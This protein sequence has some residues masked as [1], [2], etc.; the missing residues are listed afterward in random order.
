MQYEDVFEE[1]HEPD[2]RTYLGGAGGPLRHSGIGIAS[3]VLSLLAII[4]FVG[5]FVY[6]IMIGISD[7]AG[8]SGS[9]AALESTTFE[10]AAGLSVFGSIGLDLLAVVLGI[11]GCCLSNRKKIYA[12]L[13][14]CISVLT[15]VGMFFLMVI[16]TMLQ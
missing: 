11:V 16:G 13:G 15:L 2:P 3:F 6:G 9:G 5:L 1:D 7:A 4:P 12:I 8:G 14:L 10:I